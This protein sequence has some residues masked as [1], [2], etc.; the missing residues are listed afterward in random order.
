MG[1]KKSKQNEN[2]ESVDISEVGIVEEKVDL[3]MDEVAIDEQAIDGPENSDDL[4]EKRDSDLESVDVDD[5]EENHRG[6]DER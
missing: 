4:G 3:E 6:V 5:R 2:T 1:K